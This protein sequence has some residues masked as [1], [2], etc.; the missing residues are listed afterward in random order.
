MAGRSVAT[1]YSSGLKSR[2]QAEVTWVGAFFADSQAWRLAC[3]RA[4]QLR[5]FNIATTAQSDIDNAQRGK[6]F[7]RHENFPTIVQTANCAFVDSGTN[8]PRPF[9]RVLE[10]SLPDPPQN[11]THLNPVDNRRNAFH[12][13]HIRMRSRST[14]PICSLAKGRLT[15]N[16]IAPEGSLQHQ[17]PERPSGE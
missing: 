12:S 14:R 1:R 11:R 15:D 13:S 2:Q 17:E 3:S 4:L 10:R 6:H 7:P 9:P 5:I 8:Q 16:L